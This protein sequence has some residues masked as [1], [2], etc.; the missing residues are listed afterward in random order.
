MASRGAFDG[1]VSRVHRHS[2]PFLFVRSASPSL[3]HIQGKCCIRSHCLTSRPEDLRTHFKVSPS[4]LWPPS[5]AF[6]PVQNILAPPP[7]RPQKSQ[8]VT[9]SVPSP[10]SH[11]SEDELPRTVPRSA[12]RLRAAPPGGLRAESQVIGPPGPVPTAGQTEVTATHSPI[13]RSWH[14]AGHLGHRHYP[15]SE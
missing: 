11:P 7:S 15:D 10:G 13:P 6:L 2:A 3:A 14:S 9:A 5:P 12:P 1:P 4:A 8:P